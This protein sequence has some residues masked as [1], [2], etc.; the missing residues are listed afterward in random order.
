M[1]ATTGDLDATPRNLEAT[2]KNLE[3]TPRN[4]DATPRN[5]LIGKNITDDRLDADIFRD[6]RGCHL[7]VVDEFLEFLP[8]LAAQCEVDRYYLS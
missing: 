3:A 6:G 4:L 1:E 5:L 8:Q 7:H 2:P